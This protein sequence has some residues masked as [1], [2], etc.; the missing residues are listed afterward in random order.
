DG[1]AQ[2][3]DDGETE[4]KDGSAAVMIVHRSLQGDQSTAD[5]AGSWNENEKG[6]VAP[7]TGSLRV[8]RR[9]NRR[10]RRGTGLVAKSGS[11]ARPAAIRPSS[12]TPWETWRLAPPSSTT[13]AEPS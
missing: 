10:G 7:V 11:S 3:G 8:R 2:R 5:N 9:R 13:T 4:E 12:D 6:Q 1:D